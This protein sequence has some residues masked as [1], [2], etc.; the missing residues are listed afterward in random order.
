MNVQY[1]HEHLKFLELRFS[2]TQGRS[3][4]F[5]AASQN[6]TTACAKNFVV[7][8][9]FPNIVKRNIVAKRNEQVSK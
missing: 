5:F 4:T 8:Y 9:F 3:I 7:I 2:N 1:Q 6:A